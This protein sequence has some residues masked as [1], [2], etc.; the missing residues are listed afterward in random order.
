MGKS[1]IYF[2]GHVQVRKLCMFFTRPGTLF[3]YWTVKATG[4][5]EVSSWEI[6]YR[7]FSTAILPDASHEKGK[8]NAP[9]K[10]KTPENSDVEMNSN[11][12]RDILAH[13]LHV[14]QLSSEPV[15]WNMFILFNHKIG[16]IIPHD[17]YFLAGFKPQTIPV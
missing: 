13:R 6:I 16:K 14:F 2:Y 5:P 11:P 15:I 7:G 8:K 10:R 12:R 9:E 4:N 17:L 3:G 1:T